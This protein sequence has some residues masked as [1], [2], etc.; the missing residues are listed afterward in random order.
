MPL[1]TDL[2]PVLARVWALLAAEYPPLVTWKEA[3]Q[4]AL[5]NYKALIAYLGSPTGID[6]RL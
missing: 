4:G 3:P 1:L 6:S 5:P 2:P